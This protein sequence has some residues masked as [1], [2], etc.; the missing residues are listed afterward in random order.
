MEDYKQYLSEGADD[1]ERE[2]A[3]QVL[4]GLAGIR[5]EYKVEEV[6]AKRRTWLRRRFWGRMGLGAILVLIAGLMVLDFL[7][8]ENSAQQ[9]TPTQQIE[10]ISPP[11]QQPVPEQTF[12]PA[13]KE[14]IA[15]RPLNPREQAEQ[16]L[17]RG[18]QSDVDSTTN[19]LIDILLRVT[20]HNDTSKKL[21]PYESTGL[22]GDA[23]QLLKAKKPAE[24]KTII[25]KLDERGGRMSMDAQWLLGIA[26]LEEGKLEEAQAIFEKIAKDPKHHRRKDAQLAA[27]ALR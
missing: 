27:E 1:R 13:R 19:R 9:P 21:A 8:R 10:P 7:K 6:A 14:P 4:E 20:E 18:V 15:K 16:P 22:W 5:L 24:A 17:L 3:K 23:L 25:F 11:Q 26:L 12:E 2:A